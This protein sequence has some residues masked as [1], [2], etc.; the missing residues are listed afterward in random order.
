M[1]PHFIN[2][3]QINEALEFPKKKVEEEIKLIKRKMCKIH[4]KH[5]IQ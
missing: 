4:E 1:R 5:I 2:V 3:V